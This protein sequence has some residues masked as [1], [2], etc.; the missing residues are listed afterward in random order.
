[1]ELINFYWLTDEVD[2][3]LSGKHWHMFKTNKGTSK[4]M[5]GQR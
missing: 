2:S 1:M 5:G 3:E 4:L